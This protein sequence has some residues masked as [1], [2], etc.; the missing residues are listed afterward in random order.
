MTSFLD[1]SFTVTLSFVA[2][3]LFC[4]IF[5]PSEVL[6][7]VLPILLYLFGSLRL[8][9]QKL[10]SW[11]LWVG[12]V[13]WFGLVLV[14]FLFCLGFF[15]CLFVGLLFYFIFFLNLSAAV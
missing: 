12:L 3:S 7:R 14:L 5:F 9:F 6:N 11:G 8:L 13:V 2:S 10:H 4:F 15:V 1:N